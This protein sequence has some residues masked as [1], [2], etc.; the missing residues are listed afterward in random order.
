MT[1]QEFAKEHS[2]NISVDKRTIKELPP[3]LEKMIT[4]GE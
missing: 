1:I 3:Y 2:L 4:E